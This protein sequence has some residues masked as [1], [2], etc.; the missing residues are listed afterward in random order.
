MGVK[1]FSEFKDELKFEL[2]RP[3]DDSLDSY[4][5]GWINT[6]YIQ[7]TTRN[8]FWTINR[9]F[10]FP[11]LE[12]STDDDTT[13]GQ[14]YIDVPSGCLVIRTLWDSTSD[15]KLTKIS[16]REYINKTGRA[17]S[18]SEGAPTK[19]CRQGDYIYLNPTPDGTYTIYIYYRKIPTL[20]SDNDDTTAIGTEWDEPILQLAVIQSHMRLGEF[21]KAEV[22]KKEWL[23]TVG[24]LVGI[25]DQEK[26]DREDIRKPSIAYLD[27]KY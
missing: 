14:A 16:W 20:L 12:V 4:T 8:K 10:Y 18:S 5:G 17:D 9:G 15:V 24:S 23:E 19:W 6:A 27:N 25:Y 11:E 3:N 26:F 21:D 1:K 7:L 22:K 13:D 2:G